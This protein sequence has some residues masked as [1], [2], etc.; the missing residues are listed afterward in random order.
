MR[1]EG[2]EMGGGEVGC[3]EEIEERREMGE[4]DDGVGLMGRMTGG[5]TVHVICSIGSQRSQRSNVLLLT[6]LESSSS[7]FLNDFTSFL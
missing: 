1:G 2:G 6:N 7:F 4:G 5:S 3:W